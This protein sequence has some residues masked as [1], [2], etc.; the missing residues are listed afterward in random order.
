MDVRADMFNFANHPRFGQPNLAF[1]DSLFG[2][3]SSDA[4][5]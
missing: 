2:T 3:I 1:G 5:G 4:S